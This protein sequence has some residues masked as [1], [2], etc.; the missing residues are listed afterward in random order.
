VRF[1]AL[2]ITDAPGLWIVYL[3]AAIIFLSTLVTFYIPQRRVRALVTPQPDG[4]A[5]MRLGAQV[6]L[7][8]FGA[9]EFAQLADAIKGR[10]GAAPDGTQPDSAISDAPREPIAVAHD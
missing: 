7:D 3:A 8:L 2:Q 10:V 1:T 9:R 4:T 6:K 5:L